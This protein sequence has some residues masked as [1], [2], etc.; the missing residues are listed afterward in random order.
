MQLPELSPGGLCCNLG[1]CSPLPVVSISGVGRV[2]ARRQASSD[3]GEPTEEEEGGDGADAADPAG[4]EHGR[5][6]PHQDGD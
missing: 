2:K 1:D 5:V 4:A 6:G 3:R